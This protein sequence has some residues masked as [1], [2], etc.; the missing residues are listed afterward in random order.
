MAFRPSFR[1]STKPE[2]LNP[3]MTPIMNLMCVL[4]PLLLTSSQFVQVGIIELNLP[5]AVGASTGQGTA[6]DAP[7]EVEMKLDLAI[8]ITDK[9]FFISSSLA[10]LRGEGD[11]SPSVPK[12]VDGSY[13]F[14][15]LSKMLYE[16]KGKATGKFSDMDKVVIQAEPEVEYQTLVSTMDASRAI[17]L[18]DGQ[19]LS[20]F[21]EVALAAGII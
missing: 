2:D 17:K 8:T 7:K 19:I 13:N 16:L 6:I 1:Q 5:P 10:I 18:D 15:G 11:Q 12:M 4:I 20:L 3:D 9:G 21:P 14:H